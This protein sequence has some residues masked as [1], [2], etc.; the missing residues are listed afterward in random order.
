MSV[1]LLINLLSNQSTSLGSSKEV[2]QFIRQSD[3]ISSPHNVFYCLQSQRDHK[4]FL[5]ND[6]FVQTAISY[7]TPEVIECDAMSWSFDD[8]RMG[9]S[10]FFPR[11]LSICQPHISPVRLFI[12]LVRLPIDGI[13]LNGG[14]QRLRSRGCDKV[15]DHCD[16][17][18]PGV[19]YE[20]RQSV[21]HQLC[22]KLCHTPLESE[23]IDVI[24]CQSE[25]SQPQ[26]DWLTEPNKEADYD[27]LPCCYY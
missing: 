11:S 9:D 3:G 13:H 25:P 4:I 19:D 22:L 14:G 15:D 18:H 7:S 26:T 6:L 21:M 5:H 1:A 27:H 24:R 8:K 16:Y 2:D 20:R 12:L 10:P 17:H 23:Q